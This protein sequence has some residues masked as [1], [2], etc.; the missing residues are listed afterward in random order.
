VTGACACESGI[1]GRQCDRCK[2]QHKGFST[3][4]C[5]RKLNRIKVAHVLKIFLKN[6]SNLNLGVFFNMPSFP[7][8][9]QLVQ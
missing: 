6:K 7:Q 9:V 3:T 5:E 8:L 4:G 2:K 1:E